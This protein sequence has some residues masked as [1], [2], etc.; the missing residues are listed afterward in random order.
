MMMASRFVSKSSTSYA[1]RHNN[2]KRI[3]ISSHQQQQQHDNYSNVYSSSRTAMMSSRVLKSKSG[4]DDEWQKWQRW[5][6]DR[7]LYNMINR[8]PIAKYTHHSIHP[9]TS[10]KHHL[11]HHH[12]LASTTGS[13]T[14]SSSSS[15]SSS[16]AQDDNTN[17]DDGPTINKHQ[18]KPISFLHN[19]DIDI[20]YDDDGE[21]YHIISDEELRRSPKRVWKS[22]EPLSENNNEPHHQLHVQ[23]GGGGGQQHQERQKN[24]ERNMT[25]DIWR[26][27]VDQGDLTSVKDVV[28]RISVQVR[29]KDCIIKFG[30]VQTHT[31]IHTH[32]HKHNHFFPY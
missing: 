12:R 19:E 15:S 17:H 14:F 32:T 6:S 7:F 27:S 3:M 26:T 29:N 21:E 30:R 25:H 13:R 18:Q 9:I 24:M 31:H 5:D 8:Q 11:H 20:L 22:T 1:R 4:H 23:G 16:S 2:N 28:D 10:S